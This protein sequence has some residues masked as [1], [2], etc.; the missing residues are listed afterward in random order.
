M[1]GLGHRGGVYPIAV[2]ASLLM[3]GGCD[4]IRTAYEGIELGRPLPEGH[5]LRGEKRQDRST[6]WRSDAAAIPLP[7]IAAQTAV[8]ATTD[9]SGKV[10]SKRYCTSAL[11]QWLVC[12]T[13][14]VRWVIEIQVPREAWHEHQHLR[15]VQSIEECFAPLERETRRSW[16]TDRHGTYVRK[17]SVTRNEW[18]YANAF[19]IREDLLSRRV[20]D[21]LKSGDDCIRLDPDKDLNLRGPPGG[22]AFP[23]GR[24]RCSALKLP[25]G[26]VLVEVLLRTPVRSKGNVVDFL[27]W[28][29]DVWG[30]GRGAVL[31][32]DADFGRLPFAQL[33]SA[34]LFGL[35]MFIGGNVPGWRDLAAVP[36]AFAGVTR[37]G[38]DRVIDDPLGAFRVR[39]L[40]NRRIEIDYRLLR[41]YDPALLLAMWE[42]QNIE[43]RR[44]RRGDV[45]IDSIPSDDI[46]IDFAPARSGESSRSDI[47]EPNDQSEK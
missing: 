27:L 39:N 18:R 7:M 9:G 17:H 4:G 8:V 34:G 40:G 31:P 42:V 46:Q 3:I 24:A 16:R 12:Q 28:Q 25:N 19:R 15:D 11:G 45:L 38:Y 33:V 43:S 23:K 30:P 41:I 14:A 21:R 10:V 5:L 37:E 13:A 35:G 20:R 44:E 47:L 2:L 29:G 22:G 1:N 6:W 32:G 26:H 36:N